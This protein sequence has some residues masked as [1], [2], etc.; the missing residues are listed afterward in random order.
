MR[1][2]E[3]EVAKA[4][5]KEAY[6][7]L[8][9]SSEG[10][11]KIAATQVLVGAQVELA[12]CLLGASDFDLSRSIAMVSADSGRTVYTG[13]VN[14]WIAEKNTALKAAI[15][16]LAPAEVQIALQQGASPFAVHPCADVSTIAAKQINFLLQQHKELLLADYKARL[17]AILPHLK[18]L[19]NHHIEPGIKQLERFIDEVKADDVPTFCIEALGLHFFID[20]SHKVKDAA[21]KVVARDDWPRVIKFVALLGEKVAA[22]NFAQATHPLLADGS[23]RLD[24]QQA[25]WHDCLAKIPSKGESLNEIKRHQAAVV[26]NIW[27]RRSSGLSVGSGAASVSASEVALPVMRP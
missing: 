25:I 13:S 21:G 11:E 20:E 8:L 15:K 24:S 4:K 22:H 2:T 10:H 16:R 1:Q 14:N 9:F 26:A 19:T 23:L 6:S 3:I 18:A 7:D 5:L 17:S 27:R 12:Q